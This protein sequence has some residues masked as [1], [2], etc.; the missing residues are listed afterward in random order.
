MLHAVVP[1][2]AGA[3]GRRRVHTKKF[4]ERERKFP[5]Y[6]SARRWEEENLARFLR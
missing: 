2:E 5:R 1:D 4:Y 3:N 6:R